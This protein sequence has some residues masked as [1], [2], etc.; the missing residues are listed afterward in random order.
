M[1]TASGASNY[2]YVTARVKARRAALFS[3]DDYRKLMRM[4]P[5]EIARFMEESEY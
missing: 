2:E 3:R 1:S 5:G 4:G